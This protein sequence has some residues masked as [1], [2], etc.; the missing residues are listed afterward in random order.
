MK[1]SLKVIIIGDLHHNML[2]VVRSLGEAGILSYLIAYDNINKF[3]LESRYIANYNLVNNDKEIIELLIKE[4]NN[5]SQKP[6][7]ICTSDNAATLIDRNYNILESKYNI[8]NVNNIQGALTEVMDKG[9]MLKLAEEVGFNVPQSISLDLNDNNLEYDKVKFP[10]IVKPLKSI[11][12]KKEDFVIC[13]NSVELDK[14]L[15]KLKGDVVSVQ[16]QEYLKKEYE[17]SIVGVITPNTHK[18]IVPGI[19][20]KIREYPFNMGSSSYSVLKPNIQEFLDLKVVQDFFT[21]VKYVGLF[22]IEFLKVKDKLYFIEVNLRNDGNGYVP[23]T[24][25]CNLPYLY[26]LDY[27]RC[28]ISQYK[29]KVEF[30]I[31]FM[32][33]RGDILYMLNKPLNPFKWLS[34]LFKVKCFILFNKKDMGPVWF[35]L[36]TLFCKIL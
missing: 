34:D 27:L 14:A 19:I 23:T 13:E 25:G 11:F 26:I 35:Y 2:G 12:G 36:K 32:I 15:E 29:Q 24:G 21:K 9:Y 7:I 17:M 5:E 1:D 30:P 3:V 28:D 22:S 33:E 18:I 8:P 20:R 10:C 31:P 16:I 6:V 4:F